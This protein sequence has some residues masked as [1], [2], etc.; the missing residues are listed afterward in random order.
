[1]DTTIFR[2]PTAE[3]PPL[4]VD[5]AA[6]VTAA[7]AGPDDVVLLEHLPVDLCVV[8]DAPGAYPG[9]LRESDAHHAL[10]HGGAR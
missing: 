2:P 6:G 9:C 4:Y 8:E 7:T 5:I 1:M 3:T 10:V